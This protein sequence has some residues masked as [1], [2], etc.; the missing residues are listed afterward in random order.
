M[1]S[2]VF[3]FETT[4][5]PEDATYLRNLTEDCATRVNRGGILS[6]MV[7]VGQAIDIP[8][9]AAI[10]GLGYAAFAAMHFAVDGATIIY[11]ILKGQPRCEDWT[12]LFQRLV[13]NSISIGQCIACL[14]YSTVVLLALLP[15]VT[16]S[17]GFYQDLSEENRLLEQRCAGL[18]AGNDRLL[19]TNQDSLRKAARSEEELIQKRTRCNTLNK[20]FLDLN[21]KCIKL[22]KQ[23]EKDEKTINNLRYQI[24]TNRE[25]EFLNYEYMQTLYASDLT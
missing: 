25:E 9:V 20:L 4:C 22:K 24:K 13:K 3:R 12:H 2:F 6:R 18:E 7:A 8:V 11:H 21:T 14:V 15:T 1:S 10:S 5:F 16:Y 17:P 23:I 19:Q